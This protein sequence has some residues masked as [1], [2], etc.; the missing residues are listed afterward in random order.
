M[1]VCITALKCASDE[2]YKELKMPE[3]AAVAATERSVKWHYTVSKKTTL[4]LHAITSTHIN[5]V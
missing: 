1:A 4:M 5:R 2:N 3:N